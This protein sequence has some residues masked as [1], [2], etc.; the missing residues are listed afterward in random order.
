MT[1]TRDHGG[2]LDAAIAQYGG[3]RSEW[4]DLS[5]GINPVPYPVGT[6]DADLWT[7]L[8]DR[9]AMARLEAAARRAWQV[10]DAAQIVIAPGTSA[11]IAR[12][13]ELTDFSGAYIPGPTYNEHA[14]AFA[15]AYKLNDPD[16]ANAPTHIYVHPNNPTGRVWPEDSI[17]QARLTIIDESFCD[18]MPEASHIRAT[19][20]DGVV[21]LKSFGKFWGLAGLRLG[22]AIATPRTLAPVDESDV[23]LGTPEI[24]PRASLTDM[25]GPWPVSGPALELGARA[26]EDA[27]WA[28]ATRA[29]LAQEAQRLDQLMTN[30]GASLVGGTS[31]FRLYDVGEAAVWQDKLARAHVWSRRFPYS[32]NWLRL[33]LPA[34][35]RWSQ[36]EAAL[37]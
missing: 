6:L 22:F 30:H 1:D 17:G 14:A 8:P 7:A 9:T 5:T 24:L 34:P 13:P 15:A 33:G 4:L 29:R 18:L 10:P 28:E 20:Q 21:V 37:S 16:D 27:A 12:M 2:D 35:E 25:L 3:A 31:L 23:G 19:A 11:L 32:D 26:L 36:L